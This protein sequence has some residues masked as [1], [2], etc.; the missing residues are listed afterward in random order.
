M[1]AADVAKMMDTLIVVES[2]EPLDSARDRVFATAELFE[3]IFSYLP[4]QSLLPMQVVCRQWKLFI[5]TSTLLRR[6]LFMEP[7]RMPALEYK[8]IGPSRQDGQDLTLTINPFLRSLLET[9]YSLSHRENEAGLTRLWPLFR[10]F[11]GNPWA[12]YR[13]YQV[14]TVLLPNW[15]HHSTSADFNSSRKNR[16]WDQLQQ[17]AS[18]KSMLV[19]QPPAPYTLESKSDLEPCQFF[20]PWSRRAPGTRYVRVTMVCPEG[21]LAGDALETLRRAYRMEIHRIVGIRGRRRRQIAAKQARRL[22]RLGQA[23]QFPSPCCWSI[24]RSLVHLRVNYEDYQ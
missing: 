22:R 18:W 20:K 19:V 5:S 4:E 21:T 6:K 16:I 12:R 7:I 17:N 13:R 3:Q 8:P 14:L 23:Q 10:W 15:A 24:G 9:S 11:W 1:A 2:S